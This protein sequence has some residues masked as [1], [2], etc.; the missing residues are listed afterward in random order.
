MAAVEPSVIAA[1]AKKDLAT[2]D[3]AT[4]LDMNLISL[5]GTRHGTAPLLKRL[6]Q[7]C[8]DGTR[9]TSEQGKINQ[10]FLH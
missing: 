5:H 4:D 9:L 6:F 8:R 2:T 3:L 10:F 7:N 1:A